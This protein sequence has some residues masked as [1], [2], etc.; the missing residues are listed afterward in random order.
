VRLGLGDPVVFRHAK[1]GELCERFD[2]I[3]LISQG[4]IVDRARTYRGDGQCFI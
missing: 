2:T 4:R 3:V 1:A